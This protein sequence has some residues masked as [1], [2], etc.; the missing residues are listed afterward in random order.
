MKI[1]K[2]ILLILFLALNCLIITHIQGQIVTLSGR[3]FR[4]NGSDY[5][6]MIANFRTDFIYNMST[7]E[8]FTS[9]AGKFHGMN[10]QTD[11]NVQYQKNFTKLKNMGFN[12]VRITLCTNYRYDP[13]TQSRKFSVNIANYNPNT[14][15]ELDK[16]DLNYPDFDNS[17]SDLFFNHIENILDQADIAG[18][19]VILLCYGGTPGNKDLN[20]PKM[21]PTRDA[22][23]VHDYKTY[24]P[25]LASRLSGH[26]ALMAYDLYNEPTIQ[27]LD[28]GMNNTHDDNSWF[29]WKKEDLC[30]FV[31]EWY[32]AIR[33]ND[34][35]HLITIGGGDM[36]EVFSF[37]MGI[38]KLDFYSLHAYPHLNDADGNNVNNGIERFKGIM[39]WMYKTCPIPWII[40]ETGFSASD[41]VTV[42]YQNMP[43]MYGTEADQAYFA[44]QSLQA[45]RDANASGYSWW[46][47]QSFHMYDIN[48]VEFS[49]NHFG[50]ISPDLI[51]WDPNDPLLEKPAAA[52]FTGYQHP[53]PV[54]PTI[55]ANYYD[56]FEITS[57]YNPTK[58]NAVSGYVKDLDGN[59]IENAIV[60]AT[61]WLKDNVSPPAEY[62]H[63]E[64]YFP[65][66]FTDNS[67]FFEIVPYNFKYPGDMGKYVISALNITAIGSS[68]VHLGAND[69]Q[70]ENIQMAHN[71]GTVYLKRTL[72]NYDNVIFNQTYPVWSNQTQHSHNSITLYDDILEGSGSSG[73]TGIF[74]AG[75]YVA[76]L[77][78]FE[79]ELGSE[80]S[81]Y[82]I[83]IYTDCAQLDGY[84]LISNEE[85]T[86]ADNEIQ[87]SI[88]FESILIQF[89]KNKK[90]QSIVFP[91]PG[92]EQITIELTGA[93]NYPYWVRIYTM[94]GI[95]AW[96]IVIR[97]SILQTN[98]GNLPKGLYILKI[99]NEKE[100][101]IHKLSLY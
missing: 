51:P 36:G 60:V 82:I 79:S 15:W 90:L 43:Y 66:T 63:R 4:L 55:P 24:L 20:I 68:S 23:A 61:C 31:N 47:F 28:L 14:Y 11:A 48:S 9:P 83:P 86:I 59:P 67:G 58:H 54:T 91:N 30:G 52:A 42:P 73:S 96:E 89:R 41:Q 18:I 77:P 70:F 2:F 3:T 78:D 12:G 32:D 56:P 49:E 64:K 101:N 34:A 5:Y 37:D 25:H 8:Y 26:P 57:V 38:L 1:Y 33:Q 7:S 35:E 40:G 19:K 27:R 97:D 45:A 71:V 75:Q 99:E 81:L 98:L 46:E 74:T 100:Q 94:N 29:S 44:S 93:S 72:H 53:N 69:W 76:V 92:N 6:P 65:Y 21:Y 16:L 87:N 17:N 50:L 62:K 10:N 84:R 39:Y 95:L 13:I 80:L 22:Q 88:N 85:N